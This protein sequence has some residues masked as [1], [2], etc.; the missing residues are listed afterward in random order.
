MTS[1]QVAMASAAWLITCSA[2]GQS[3]V[4]GT[5]EGWTELNVRSESGAIR[6]WWPGTGLRY[7]G[8]QADAYPGGQE[9]ASTVVRSDA[10]PG[11]A[12]FS[13][14]FPRGGHGAVFGYLGHPG[15]ALPGPPAFFALRFSGIDHPE[16]ASLGEWLDVSSRPSVI[17]VGYAWRSLE[18]E[19]SAVSWYPSDGQKPTKTEPLLH[20]D[21]QSTRLSFRPS[22]RWTLQVSRGTLVGLDQVVP[23]DS[24]RR[25]AIS[26]SYRQPFTDG[27]WQATLA[28]GRTARK[29]N[30]SINGYL[31]ES[32]LRFQSAHTIFGRLEQ[33]GRDDL[34]QDIGSSQRTSRFNKLTVGYFRDMQN[35]GP[36]KFDVGALMSKH[37]VPTGAPLSSGAEPVSYML[38]LRLRL[39]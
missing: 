17:S 34:L 36:L 2:C 18:F 6:K 29:F 15:D 14:R 28:W 39:Q 22:E 16:P 37:F 35:S 12:N 11:L 30:E 25:S 5:R 23:S 24:L 31:L 19:G 38:F 32:A 20:L 33:V 21:A 13:F 3:S 4:A 10:Q 8:S 7:G 1:L 27:E 9:A 26:A